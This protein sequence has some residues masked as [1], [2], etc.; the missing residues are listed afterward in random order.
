MLLGPEEM[1]GDYAGKDLRREVC[2]SSFLYNG[3]DGRV[4]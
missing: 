4:F 2:I 3:S 1:E